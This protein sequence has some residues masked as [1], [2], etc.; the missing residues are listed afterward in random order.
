[1]PKVVAPPDTPSGTRSLRLKQLVDLVLEKLPKPH[2]EDVIE[3]VFVAIEANADWRKSYD[4]MV[5]ES[6]KPAVHSWAGFWISHAEQRTG[7]QRETAARS[8]L[9]ESYSKLVAPATKRGKKVREPEALKVMHDHY[10][11]NRAA[12]GPD[13]RDH[14]EVIVALIMDGMTVEKAFAQAVE[15]P[16]FAW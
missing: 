15:R 7:D 8:S 3:D 16:A 9:I 11:A 14:R 2:T 12:L 6:G 13:I 4:R 10:L 1:M 5:Y